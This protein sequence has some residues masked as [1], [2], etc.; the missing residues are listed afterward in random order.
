MTVKQKKLLRRIILGGTLLIAAFVLDR[1]FELHYLIRLGIFLLPYLAVGFSVLKK[2]VSNLFHG[3]VFDENFLMSLATVGAIAVSELPE[4]VF[5]MLFY[6]I[7]ELFESIAVGRS[8]KSITALMDLRP[9]TV[10]VLRG[11]EELTVDPDEVEIGEITVIRAGERIA[12]DGTV[13]SGSTELDT[14]ALTG[15][16]LPVSVGEGSRV[17]SGSVNISGAVRVRADKPYGE[18]AAA[19]ILDLVTEASSSKAKSEAFITRFSKYYTPTVVIIAFIIAFVPPIFDRDLSGWVTKALNLL[20]ISC[21]CALVISV[22]LTFFAGIGSASSN[23]VLIKGSHYIER[24]SR[25]D[26]LVFDKTG[27]L[28]NGCFS[29]REINP[30]GISEKELLSFAEAAERFSNHPAAHAVREAFGEGERLAVET[31]EE[32]AGMGVTVTSEGGKIAVGNLA[33]MEKTGVHLQSNEYNGTALHVCVD[34]VYKGHIILADTVK[35]GSAKALSDLKKQGVRR[36]IMLT[37]DNE[38]AAKGVCDSLSMIDGFKASLLPE[39]KVRAVRALLDERKNG[40][41]VF[42][43]DG[44]NDAPVLKLA[45]VGI[46]M[47]GV[48][49]DAAIEASDAVIIDDKLEKLPAAVR[50]CRKTAHIVR[51]N[52]AFS[53][54]VKLSVMVLSIIGLCPM[55]LAVF[56]DVGV[57]AIAVLNALRALKK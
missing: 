37:G 13:I 50:I 4:A 6:Q 57:M 29:V 10:R 31:S 48:G 27:T 42:V 14:S 28:T 35:E 12:L 44:I 24:L 43:G 21:P 40:S 33:L 45:D 17:L 36:I 32:L 34:G 38:A 7:G 52:I 18:G 46:A 8:R 56:A 9:D 26:T 1:F 54:A 47:G 11:G 41:L 30:C 55:Y 20:V 25:V 15:E 23:G 5:V 2:A 39:D 16:S 49:S 3:Q 51:Q 19:R 53:I 22:P